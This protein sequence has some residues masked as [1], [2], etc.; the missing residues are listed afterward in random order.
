[1]FLRGQDNDGAALNTAI[2]NLRS[3]YAVA[4]DEDSWPYSRAFLL[5]VHATGRDDLVALVSCQVIFG[6]SFLFGTDG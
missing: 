3:G 2:G 1:M 4:P 6:W 5:L